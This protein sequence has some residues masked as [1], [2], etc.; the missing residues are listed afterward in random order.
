MKREVL[1]E[2]ECDVCQRQI[3]VYRGGKK[4]GLYANCDGEKGCGLRLHFTAGSPSAE[5]LE[6]ELKEA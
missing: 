5:T 4:G 3:P 1:G 6:K 2:I